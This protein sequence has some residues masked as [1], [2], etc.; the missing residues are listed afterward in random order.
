MFGD[1]EVSRLSESRRDRWR[2]DNIGLVF[3]NFH[4]IDELSPRDNVLVAAWFDRW[5]AASLGERAD[6]LLMRLGVP[7]KR[8]SLRG[9]SR[10]ERQ[11]VAFARALMF[12]PP[13]VL[14]DEPTASLDREAAATVIALLADLAHSENRTVVVVSHD[15]GLAAAADRVVELKRGRLAPALAAAA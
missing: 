7:G 13:V 2:R 6:G 15:Q 4:L 12:D 3:Q 1:A 11:R 10:G 5:S 8:T 14:A 9:L